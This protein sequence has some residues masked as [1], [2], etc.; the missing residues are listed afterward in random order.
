MATRILV[1]LAFLAGWLQASFAGAVITSAVNNNSL[2]PTDVYVVVPGGL[3]EDVD[4]FI[5]RPH[6]YNDI[7]LSLLGADYVRTANDDKTAGPGFSVNVTVDSTADL[8]LFIDDR[9]NVAAAMPWVGGLGFL[10]T[11]QDIGIDEDGDGVGAGQSIDNWSSVY[12]LESVSAGTT[13]L[14]EQNDGGSRNMYGVAAVE[15]V[16]PP[17][18]VDLSLDN[19]SF[20]EGTAPFAGAPGW[21]IATGSG[22]NEFYTTAGAGLSAGDPD[23]GQEGSGSQFLTGNRQAIGDG[24]NPSSSSATQSIDISGFAIDID[25]GG[26]TLDLDFYY[27]KF[28]S[29]ESASVSVEFFD[30]GNASLGTLTT[31]SLGTTASDEW[32]PVILEGAVPLNARSFELQLNASRSSGTGTNVSFDNFSATLVGVTGIIPEPSTFIIWT[33]GLLGLAWHGRRR[34]RK[35]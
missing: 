6:E 19:P 2:D 15:F 11:G 28:D 23:S 10:D 21:T 5:D 26:V 14:L 17:P 22:A 18:S 3:A 20:E 34:R 8:Y 30:A 31:G 4:C 25:T 35:A 13:V 33:L 1:L 12:K 7:P 32:V 16:P 9:V 27:N 24:S 29:N